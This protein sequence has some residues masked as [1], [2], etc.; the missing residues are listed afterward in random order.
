MTITVTTN[1]HTYIIDDPEN[2]TISVD[3]D[4]GICFDTTIDDGLQVFRWEGSS[5]ADENM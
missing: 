4:E 1:R 2:L 5:H 3:S